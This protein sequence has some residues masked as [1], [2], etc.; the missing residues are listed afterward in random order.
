MDGVVS[1]IDDGE[2]DFDVVGHLFDDS[3]EGE[4]SVEEEFSMRLD[5]RGREFASDSGLP[6]ERR[7]WG[8]ADQH[9]GRREEE[10]GRGKKRDSLHEPT[11][12]LRIPLLLVHARSKGRDLLK[13][14]LKRV[15]G[16]VR[17]RRSGLEQVLE[18]FDRAKQNSQRS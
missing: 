4:T 13:R 17:E 10:L 16:L 2:S 3:S 9:E 7:G 18:L 15:V 6:P 11:T 12:R 5:E 8:K 14:I 1:V